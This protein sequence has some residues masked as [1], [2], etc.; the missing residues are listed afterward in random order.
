[1]ARGRIHVN[2]DAENSGHQS[3]VEFLRRMIL[4]V[5]PAFIATGEIEV[6]IRAEHHAAGVVELLL[7][8][9]LNQNRFGIRIDGELSVR[10]VEAGKAPE[11]IVGVGA[12]VG[13]GAPLVRDI[14][15]T[16]IGGSG[17]AE[18]RMK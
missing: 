5:S 17:L 11:R 14:Y 3:L 8:E 15:K 1:M 18:L 7:V 6:A 2:V 10:D 4:V 16:A 12:S 9:L 13:I